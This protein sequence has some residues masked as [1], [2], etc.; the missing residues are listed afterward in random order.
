LVNNKKGRG[1]TKNSRKG[2][3]MEKKHLMQGRRGRKAVRAQDGRIYSRGYR[4]MEMGNRNR[5]LSVRKEDRHRG[6]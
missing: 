3:E 1:E 4:R 6:P 5:R 2:S